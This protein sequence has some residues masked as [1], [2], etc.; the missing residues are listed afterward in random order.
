MSYLRSLEQEYVMGDTQLFNEFDVSH[1]ISNAKSAITNKVEAV[2]MN[3]KFDYYTSMLK[4]AINSFSLIKLDKDTIRDFLMKFDTLSRLDN[5]NNMVRDIT[6]SDVTS[7]KPQYLAQYVSMVQVAIDRAVRGEITQEEIARF[8]GGDVTEKVERQVVK[9]TLPFGL[10]SKDLV[11]MDTTKYVKADTSYVKGKVI[12][13]VSKYDQIK[14]E[15]LTEANAVMNAIQESEENVKAM[16]SVIEKIKSSGNIDGTKIQLLNQI[17]YNSIRGIIEVISYISFMLIHKL[18]TISS[19]IIACNDLYTDIS[20][21]YADGNV[22]ESAF[23]HNIF[24]TDIKS[25]TEGLLEGKSAAYESLATNIYEY[26]GILPDSSNIENPTDANLVNMEVDQHEYDRTA[27][28]NIIKAYMEISVGLDVI[29]VEADEFLL[30][31]DDII[32]KSGFLIVLEERFQN[33]LREIQTVSDGSTDLIR[34]LAEVKDFGNNMSTIAKVVYETYNKMKFLQNRYADNIN[35]EYTDFETINELKIFL[36][37]LEEQYKSM[38]EKVAS[39]CYDRIK[40]LGIKVSN[41]RNNTNVSTNANTIPIETSSNLDFSESQIDYKH[42]MFNIM[43]E[44]YDEEHEN[45]FNALQ[46]SYFAEKELAL[47]GVKA[48]FEADEPATNTATTTNVND[49]NAN[50]NDAKNNTKV[51]V[52]DNNKSSNGSTN[53]NSGNGV[54]QK[55]STKISEFINNAVQRFMEFVGRTSNKNAEWL[56]DN[57]DELMGRPYVNVALN[58]LPYRNITPDKIISDAQALSTNL[59]ALTL[60]TLKTITKKDQLYGKLFSFI[61]N[62]SENKTSDGSLINES[63]GTL[64]EQITKYYKVGTAELN[65][66]TI[67]NGELKNEITNVIFPFCEDYVNENGFRGR[68]K[69]ALNAVGKSAESIISSYNDTTTTESVS[70]F[71]EVSIGKDDVQFTGS[72]GTSNTQVNISEKVKWIAE[73]VRYFTGSVLNAVR[74][75]NNDYLKALSSLLPKTPKTPVE[76]KSQNTDNQQTQA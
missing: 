60:D 48:I 55:L 31:Y 71:T 39:A 28:E 67:A 3:M 20:N 21:I 76:P 5:A 17:S 51:S 7:F 37:G 64:Q 69:T 13:F 58:I 10:Q 12:P 25:L 36:G 41:A 24:P 56:K 54:F 6:H 40:S 59:S 74:D 4:K 27:Y 35:G 63:K 66:I 43:M 62:L 18:N 65:T 52:Q 42:I 61:N 11:K 34:L 14:N 23:D 38:T 8:I 2:N 57:K 47:R 15:A 53:N 68:L 75:R 33:E 73:A 70:I 45:Y 1:F 49:T 44:Y 50:N 9:T 22:N 30:I 16:L 32:K 26:H 29:S 46:R 72:T 19:N